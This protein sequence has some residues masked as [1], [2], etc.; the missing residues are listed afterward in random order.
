V[1]LVGA[2]AELRQISPRSSCVAA[3]IR[4]PSAARVEEL[5]VL[6]VLEAVDPLAGEADDLVA[7][8]RPGLGR[9]PVLCTATIAGE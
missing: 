7:G 9:R 4:P 2:L 3:R 5:R 8:R 1:V 6:D